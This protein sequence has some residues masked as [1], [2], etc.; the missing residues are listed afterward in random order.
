MA[1]TVIGVIVI[2]AAI[3]TDADRQRATVGRTRIGPTTGSMRATVL[4]VF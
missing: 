4:E 3:G 2:T 1:I